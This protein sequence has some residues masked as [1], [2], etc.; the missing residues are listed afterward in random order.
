MET[1]K[2]LLGLT[3]DELK[4]VAQTYGL[5][6]FAGKQMADWLYRKQVRDIALMTNLPAR[7]REAMA[8]DWCIGVEDP[9]QQQTS[10][11]GTVKHLFEVGEADNRH[12][13]ESVYIPDGDRATLC[14]SSQM[15]CQMGC[16]FCA[17]GRQGFQGNLTVAE[18]LNQVQSIGQPETLT[19]VVFMGMGEPLNNTGQVLRAIDIM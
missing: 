3:C 17:T 1:R 15:G 19:N 12:N 7:A 4:A 2:K 8:Q 16:K 13:I 10:K 9:I 18:I 6:A 5:P 11:D 14:I